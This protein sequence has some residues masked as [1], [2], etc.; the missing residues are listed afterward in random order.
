MTP[1]RTTAVLLAVALASGAG[2]AG[3]AALAGGD[4]A[5][6]TT[7]T[8]TTGTARPAAAV[9][10]EDGLSVNEIVR[11]TKDGVVDIKVR[12]SGGSTP[13]R[14][15]GP[16]GDGGAPRS[17]AEGSGFVIDDDG[18][19]VTNQHVVDG[20]TSIT[21]TFANGHT[22]SAKVVGTDA[23]TDVAVIK[24]DAPKSELHPLTLADSA[25]VQVGDGV[26][27][28]GSPFGLTG[29]VTTGIVSALGR[30]INAPNGFTISGAIQTDA[31]INHGNSGGPLLD[32]AGR[33]IGINA[34]IESDS[35]GN[36]GVGF[37]IP[38]ST[39]RRVAQQLI[40]G[41]SVAH[42]YLGV[43]LT[44]ATGGAGVAQVRGAGPAADAGL[45]VGDVVTAIDGKP[46]RSADALVAAVDSHEPGDEVTLKVRRDGRIRDVD[47]KLGTRPS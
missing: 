10:T 25:Q 33:V 31:A 45:E 37:A 34:Q 13:D 42:A 41:G 14:F 19:I 3:V 38:S 24:A 6:A 23:S 15:G 30:T 22:A 32:A 5:A 16:G 28:I 36:D 47:V 18:H 2:G 43:Q 7:V 21:V 27:A 12:S 8:T 39:V 9:K 1:R 26:V 44:D 29:T 40:S 11:R 17:Q 20:A 46:V 35:G 4:G